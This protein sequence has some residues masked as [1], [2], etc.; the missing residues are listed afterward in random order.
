MI[1]AAENA[2]TN[3]V[4]VIGNKTQQKENNRYKCV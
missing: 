3:T 1:G 4:Y 2:I